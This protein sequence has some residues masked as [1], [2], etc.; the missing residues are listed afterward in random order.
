MH[1]RLQSAELKATTEWEKIFSYHTFDKGL[2]SRKY[3]ELL[4]P[5]PT[6]PSKHRV[7]IGEGLEELFLQR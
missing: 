1:Q 6:K 4:Q 3:K 2:V 7:K 5:N